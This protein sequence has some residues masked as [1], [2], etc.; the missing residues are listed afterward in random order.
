MQTSSVQ[1]LAG[2]TEAMTCFLWLALPP[3]PHSFIV[4][5]DC[6][7]MV[8]PGPGKPQA[9][10]HFDS[11]FWKQKQVDLCKLKA[12]LVYIANPSPARAT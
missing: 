11:V 7:L 10:G 4:Q 1:P 12:S 9:R 5:S 2:S 3:F 8:G 6:A